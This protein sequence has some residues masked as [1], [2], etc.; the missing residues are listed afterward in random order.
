MQKLIEGPKHRG[1]K[2]MPLPAP[3]RAFW[4]FWASQDWRSS[5]EFHQKLPMGCCWRLGSSQ[6]SFLPSVRGSEAI[7]CPLEVSSWFCSWWL[8]PF[9]L[10]S[11]CRIPSS[12]GSSFTASSA[13]ILLCWPWAHRASLPPPT[14]W[15]TSTVPWQPCCW[16]VGTSS[17]GSPWAAPI[18]SPGWP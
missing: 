16:E 13:P 15:A 5:L 3:L 9:Q 2:F 8:S 10:S 12:F 14:T 18:C 7:L 4:A 1:G 11:L 17:G 6:K